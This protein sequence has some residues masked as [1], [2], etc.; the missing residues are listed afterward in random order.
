MRKLGV[1]C[2]LVILCTL[3]VNTTVLAWPWGSE[4]LATIN[5]TIFT[6]DDFKNW[7]FN[8]KEKHSAF[9]ETPDPFVDWCLLVQEAK[10]MELYNEPEYRHKINVFLKARTLLLYKGD[11]INSRIAISDQELR[12][13]Y[14]EY[15]LPRLQLRLLYFNDQGTARRSYDFIKEKN[16]N[17]ADFALHPKET[18]SN[19]FY[20]EEKLM[21]AKELPA[22]WEPVVDTLK[23]GSIAEPITWRKGYVII[24]L[25]EKH[26]YDV[27]DFEKLKSTL[28]S[29]IREA[30]ERE[31]TAA[32]IENL[33]GKYHVKINDAVYDSLD[34]DSDNT[35]ILDET[36]FSIENDAYNV[37]SFL[38]L[39][40]KELSFRKEYGFHVQDNETLKKQLLESVFAQTLTTK[41][42][43]DEHYEEREPLKAIYTFYTQHR[44]IRELENRIFRPQVQ[45]EKQDLIKYYQQNSNH[46]MQPETVAIA[47]VEDDIET[48][49]KI[50]AIMKRG[51]DLFEAAS[52][53]YSGEVSVKKIQYRLLDPVVQNV[54]DGLVVGQA[55]GPFVVNG[56]NTIIQLIKRTP[57]S[58]LS[59]EDL[60]DKLGE[61]VEAEKFSE[62]RNR[63]LAQL[64]EK[65]V[66][67]INQGAWKK[68]EKEFGEVYVAQ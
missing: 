10:K 34:F 12:D 30:K 54:I 21:R 6:T 44:L 61:F 4:K 28:T 40:N 63:Y 33:K 27:N 3:A 42:A 8:W 51:S 65:S 39:V 56:H 57:A 9:P 31:L 17:I 37:R 32:L 59:Y 53:F 66:I 67:D 48:I 20:Y 50:F 55:S 35:V 45:V 1:F 15:Y 43:L 29:E 11:M 18:D 22:A 5:G 2:C 62:V 52:H 68:L 7:W 64:K 25:Y 60:H 38:Q 16:I 24:S 58:P 47:V 13:R 46:F 14:K 49:E 36:L 19:S 41:A 26:G 23:V